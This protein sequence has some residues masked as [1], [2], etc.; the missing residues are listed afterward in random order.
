MNEMTGVLG[1]YALLAT[2]LSLCT[3]L[4]VTVKHDI[5]RA[6]RSSDLERAKLLQEVR[7]LHA[8]VISVQNRLAEAEE[9]LLAIPRIQPP[10]PGMNISRRSQIIRLHRR[11]ERPEQI[12]ASLGLPQGEVDLLLKLHLASQPNGG[13]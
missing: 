5:Q 6:K 7:Q 4:F 11:G 8:E 13:P 9:K 3:F 12:A 10:R 1:E 2:G